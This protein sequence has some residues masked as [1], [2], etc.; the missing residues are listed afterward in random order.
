MNFFNQ[1][2]YLITINF[3]MYQTELYSEMFRI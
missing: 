1:K 3:Q 2:S